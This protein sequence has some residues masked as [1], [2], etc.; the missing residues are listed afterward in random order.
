MKRKDPT[1]KEAK[2]IEEVLRTGN[3]SKS[4]LAAGYSSKSIDS[5]AYRLMHENPLVAKKLEEA[6]KE[7]LKKMVYTLE[8]AMKELDRAIS[9]AYETKNANALAKMLEHRS[10]LHGLLIE[11]HDVR[12]SG[13]VL[14]LTGIQTSISHS[15]D[16]Q[17][18][19]AQIVTAAITHEKEEETEEE[20]NELFT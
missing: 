11:K 14:D 20:E 8:T 2:F 16:A 6:R 12:Q 7:V 3:A 17:T 13:F 18:I 4:A 10:K 1:E 5:R 9:F 15:I 19:N